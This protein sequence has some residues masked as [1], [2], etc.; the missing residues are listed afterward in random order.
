MENTLDKD[1]EKTT[2]NSDDEEDKK[3]KIKLSIKDHFM[4]SVVKL[5]TWSRFPKT[6]T[7]CISCCYHFGIFLALVILVSYSEGGKRCEVETLNM[8]AY[9]TGFKFLWC[10]FEETTCFLVLIKSILPNAFALINIVFFFAEGGFS[11]YVFYITSKAA[12]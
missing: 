5:Y 4:L 2:P 3:P 6:F 1:K 8:I 9:A 12:D 11:I 10:T 7:S